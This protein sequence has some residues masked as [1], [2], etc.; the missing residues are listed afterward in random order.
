MVGVTY[1]NAV[2]YRVLNNFSL[3]VPH[4]QIVS[5]VGDVKDVADAVM[6]ILS[7]V[8]TNYKGIVTQL[9]LPADPEYLRKNVSVC[10]VDFLLLG[11]VT[12][13]TN[14]KLFLSARDVTGTRTNCRNFG[15]RRHR[16]SN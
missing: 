3:V 7:G 2:G 12:I 4:G 5:L 10:P 9:G 14:V 13:S 15:L 8:C 11:R 6:T 16:N 1:V